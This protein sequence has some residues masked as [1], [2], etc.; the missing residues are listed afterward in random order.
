MES[1]QSEPMTRSPRR[2][3][4]MLVL[5]QEGLRFWMISSASREMGC[6][7]LLLVAEMMIGRISLFEFRRLALPVKERTPLGLI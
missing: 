4:A 5:L 1:S 7:R 3:A 6:V 2:L